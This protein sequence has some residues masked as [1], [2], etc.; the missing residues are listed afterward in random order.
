[1]ARKHLAAGLSRIK[2]SFS[3]PVLRGLSYHFFSFLA[4]QTK[5]LR[6]IGVVIKHSFQKV[7]YTLIISHFVFKIDTKKVLKSGKLYHDS[8]VE[9]GNARIT[10]VDSEQ[11]NAFYQNKRI[12]IVNMM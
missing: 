7:Y 6:Y 4:F 11:N 3:R 5:L 9:G 8:S 10:L 12:H 1:M 2:L